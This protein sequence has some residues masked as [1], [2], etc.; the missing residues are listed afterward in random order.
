MAGQYNLAALGPSAASIRLDLSSP[1]PRSRH[2]S[3]YSS[4]RHRI[5]VHPVSVTRFRCLPSSTGPNTAHQTDAQLARMCEDRSWNY[6]QT[7][8][9]ILGYAHRPNT[10]LAQLL[11][12]RILKKP[13]AQLSPQTYYV[14][15]PIRIWGSLR[16]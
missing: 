13:A 16:T 12:Y 5:P 6:R 15:S 10:R 9:Q 4:R 11:G 14:E 1:L 2:T 3:S 7:R 8:P